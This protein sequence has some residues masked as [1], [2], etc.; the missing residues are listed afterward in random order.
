MF[1]NGLFS[2]CSILDNDIRQTYL[3]CQL[4]A[5][6]GER[7]VYRYPTKDPHDTSIDQ[8]AMGLTALKVTGNNADYDRI[9]ERWK[10]TWKNLPN[11]PWRISIKFRWTLGSYCWMRK[12][13]GFAKFFMF[14]PTLFAVPVCKIANLFSKEGYP[15]YSIFLTGL[16]LYTMQNV[17]FIANRYMKVI[18]KD[19]YFLKYLLTKNRFWL[20]VGRENYE[21]M[22]DF[23]PMRSLKHS[24]HLRLLRSEEKTANNIDYLIFLTFLRMTA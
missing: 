18:D 20:N 10:F 3:N 22:S 12:W 13:H 17:K 19:N 14:W 5:L 2:I 23:R 11:K 24:K 21:S 9:I 15:A 16:M 1:F 6:Y 4:I 7:S 8:A